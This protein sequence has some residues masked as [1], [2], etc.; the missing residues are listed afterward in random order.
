MKFAL[1]GSVQD[2]RRWVDYRERTIFNSH[3]IFIV[4][5]VFYVKSSDFAVYLGSDISRVH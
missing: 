2:E 1:V 3:Q 5:S 4:L